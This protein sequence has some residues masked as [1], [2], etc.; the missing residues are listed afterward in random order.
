MVNSLW[1]TIDSDYLSLISKNKKKQSFLKDCF[2]LC[3]V[4]GEQGVICSLS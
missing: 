4:K 1:L 2:F 3:Y